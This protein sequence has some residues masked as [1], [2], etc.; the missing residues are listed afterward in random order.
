[1]E[2]NTMSEDTSVDEEFFPH[3]SAP[4]NKKK[5]IIIICLFVAA[6][7]VGAYFLRAYTKT[8]A[9][10]QK[11]ADRA[12]A[13]LVKDVSKLIL[14]PE[15]NPAVFDVQDPEMLIGQ[16]AFFQGSEKGDKLLVYPEAGKAIIYSPKKHMIINVGPVT[17]DQK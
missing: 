17:F 5:K 3:V 15:G 4:K 10:K 11:K 6:V 1:M 7:L 2:K 12:V 8:D 14:L 13:V 9:Y 16:Q